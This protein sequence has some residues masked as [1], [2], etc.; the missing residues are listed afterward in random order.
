[1]LGLMFQR[2]SRK[3]PRTKKMIGKASGPVDKI[4]P[5]TRI[6]P[7]HFVLNLCRVVTLEIKSKEYLY[8][9]TLKLIKKIPQAACMVISYH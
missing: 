6:E 4:G 1:M 8:Y 7:E 2:R 5:S 9:Q 3:I